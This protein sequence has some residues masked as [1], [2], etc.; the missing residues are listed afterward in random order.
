M[1]FKVVFPK[2][3]FNRLLVIVGLLGLVS[4]ALLSA[5]FAYHGQHYPMPMVFTLLAPFGCLA[6]GLLPSLQL[7]KE[8]QAEQF[9]DC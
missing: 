7:Q 5:Y 6:W 8:Q 3:W 9:F 4:H 1:S 2:R